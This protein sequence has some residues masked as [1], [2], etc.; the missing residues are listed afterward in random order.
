MKC[1]QGKISYVLFTSWFLSSSI[2]YHFGRFPPPA[3]VKCRLIQV[4]IR[5]FRAELLILSTDLYF[6]RSA[7]HVYRYFACSFTALHAWTDF[8][9][10]CHAQGLNSQLWRHQIHEPTLESTGLLTWSGKR[11][12]NRFSSKSSRSTSTMDRI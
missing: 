2:F 8:R 1:Q 9:T 4:S 7:G 12:H 3:F 5:E 6:S 11:E 10:H